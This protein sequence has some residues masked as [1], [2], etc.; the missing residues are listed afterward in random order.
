M[1]AVDPAVFSDLEENDIVFVDST[2]VAKTG[3]D[4][5]WIFRELVPDLPRGVLL[6]FHDVFYPFEY[7]H[8]WVFEGRGWNRST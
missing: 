4:V 5:E 8:A 3:S 2:H 1:Q 7:P 6:H